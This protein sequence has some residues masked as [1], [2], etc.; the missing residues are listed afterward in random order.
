ALWFGRQ[1]YQSAINVLS[2]GIKLDPNDSEFRLMKARIYLN[3]G[4]TVEAVNTLK[5]LSLVKDVEYQ[6]LLASNAQQISQ[7]ETA[8]IAYK[9]LSTLEP[10]AGRWW[11]GL[12][13]AYDSNSEF[14]HAK[15]SYAQALEKIDLSE[16]A[17]QFVRQRLQELGE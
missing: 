14:E 12:A 9:L 17:R 3:Q 11:L 5:V 1:S 8:K 7:H 15:D 4:K 2:Q 13:V 6:A 10:N 16:N